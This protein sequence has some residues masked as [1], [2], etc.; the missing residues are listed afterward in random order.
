MS[1]N[2]D[3]R[4]F[5]SIANSDTGEVGSET[6]FHYHQESDV[7]WAEYAGGEIVRGMFIAKVL[8]DDSL[9]MRYQHTNRK[10]ELQ[11]GVC[12]SVPELLPDGRMRLHER[13]QWTC[14]DHSTGESTIEQIPSK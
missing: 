10:G 6:V 11:T 8:K 14:G 13:W 12:T 1:I 2:Y 7:V 4:S 3:N 5:R 9:D